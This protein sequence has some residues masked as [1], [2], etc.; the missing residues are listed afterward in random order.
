MFNKHED[1][2]IYKYQFFFAY[3]YY[4]STLLIALKKIHN[5]KIYI[6]RYIDNIKS[7]C[8]VLNEFYCSC[9]IILKQALAS[10]ILFS[11]SNALPLPLYAFGLESIWIAWS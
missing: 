6:Y 5:L 1:I 4:T 3:I 9:C 8:I 11:L 2:I 7:G 10:F